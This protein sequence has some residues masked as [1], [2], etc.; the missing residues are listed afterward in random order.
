MKFPGKEQLPQ[1]GVGLSFRSEMANAIYQ[2]LDELDF[3]EVIIDNALNGSLDCQFAEAVARTMPIVGHGV[4]ASLGYLGLIDEKYLGQVGGVARSMRCC[5][6][7]EHL[8]YTR[9]EEL[10]TGQLLPIQLTENNVLFVAEKIRL[11]SAML[12][13]PFLIENIVSY[14]TI[15]GS[16]MPETEFLVRLMETAHCGLLLDVN[17]LYA[18]SINHNF[19]PRAFMDRLPAAAVVEIHVAGGELRDGLYIDTHGHAINS[20]V[21][22][23][24]EYAIVTKRPNAIVLEREKNFPPIS[25]LIS[26]IRELR[27][28][29]GRHRGEVRKRSSERERVEEGDVCG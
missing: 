12:G 13:L 6:F 20:A 5:W 19:D 23:L 26:E 17:N 15:P 27:R 18:N 24:L 21:M 25:E 3:M 7:S 1:L 29:W 22:E 2:N 9:S 16:T 28:M 8:A 14:F 10:D 11:T 4:N